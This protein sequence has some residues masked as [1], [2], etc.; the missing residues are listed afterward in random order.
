MTTNKFSFSRLAKLVA[1][2]FFVVSA[3]AAFAN[4]TWN[5]DLCGTSGGAANGAL[6]TTTAAAGT[7]CT[8]I[9]GVQA[10]NSVH[11]YAYSAPLTTNTWTGT[12]VT[13][14]QHGSGSGL[15]VKGFSAEPGSPEHAIDNHTNT[16]LVA[17]RFDSA[18]TLKQVTLGWTSNDADFSLLAWTGGSGAAT[19]TSTGSNV[20]AGRTTAALTA[21]PLSLTSGGW[22]VVGNYSVAVQS[23]LGLDVTAKVN[24]GNISSSWWLVSAYNAGFAVANN[25]F[26]GV[27]G[28]AIT[29]TSQSPTIGAL[30]GLD[31]F[32][33]KSVGNRVP[34][35]G[36]LALLGIGL[37]GAFVARR[38][39]RLSA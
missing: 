16:E 17:L 27:S 9:S 32:K 23:P 33:L 30:G 21:T 3:P 6:V 2:G 38:R 28:G 11:A 7:G 25:C 34:E 26:D 10:T 22:S 8:Q 37:L 20:I 14:L 4:T 1:A 19:P 39:T 18:V 5:L 24:A 36:S 15:G 13:L 35:P 29:C 12:G 31:Y